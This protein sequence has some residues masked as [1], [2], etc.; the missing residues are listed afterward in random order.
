MIGDYER[1]LAL[2][3]LLY[4][5]KGLSANNHYDKLLNLGI[6]FLLCGEEQEATSKDDVDFD[7]EQ[8]YRLIQAS[9]KSDYGINLDKDKI[10]WWD[11]YMYLNGLTDKC[12]LN[13]VRELRTY[14]TTQI[15]DLKEKRKVEKMKNKFALKKKSVP[16]TNK[17]QESVE[18]F[19]KLTGLKRKE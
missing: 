7:F 17:Q 6:K 14:D 15:K 18:T 12:I 10:H 16:L 9:F 13:R 8:D 19:Y 2:I 5:D 11:F 4:G 3:Y 1:S